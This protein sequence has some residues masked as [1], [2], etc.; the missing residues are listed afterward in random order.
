[1]ALA[2]RLKIARI[3]TFDRRDFGLYRPAHCDRFDLL[4]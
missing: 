4:P 2:E 1:M 3:L